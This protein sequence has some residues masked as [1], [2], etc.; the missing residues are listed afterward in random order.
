M[1]GVHIRSINREMS[2]IM[3]DKNVNRPISWRGQP[4]TPIH[5]LILERFDT[6]RR[7]VMDLCLVIIV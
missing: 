3:I 4:N 1:N 5:I 6:L 7:G 2:M